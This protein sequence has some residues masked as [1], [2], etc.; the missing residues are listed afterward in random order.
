MTRSEVQVPH[1]PPWTD[2]R[3]PYGRLAQLARAPR[4][5]RGGRGFEPLSAHHESFAWTIALGRCLFYI[6][7]GFVICRDFRAGYGF[8]FLIGLSIRADY[9]CILRL[10]RRVEIR[11]WLAGQ[12]VEWGRLG[13]I[14]WLTWLSNFLRWS[15]LGGFLWGA[16]RR[17][18]YMG[19]VGRDEN[20]RS[21][22]AAW[23][24]S[25]RCWRCRI[26]S[27]LELVVVA[28]RRRLLRTV[29]GMWGAGCLFAYLLY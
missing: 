21:L 19:S 9:F 7:C 17:R 24:I 29:P 27:F 8:H 11:R 25:L 22:C 20:N 6:C 15:E 28:I 14:V 23:S 2:Y 4:L 10:W 16:E 26:K 18:A 12:R 5:H 13:V 3:T 1:R